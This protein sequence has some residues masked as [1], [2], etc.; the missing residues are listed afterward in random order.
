M[1]KVERGEQAPLLFTQQARGRI[2]AGLGWD[3]R[4][5]KVGMFG[6]ILKTDS[7][8]DLDITAYI[9]NKDGEFIDF[10]GAEAQDSM[11]DSGKIYH[12]GDDMSG[13]GDGDD[14]FI[15]AELMELPGNVHA[16]VFLVEIRSNHVFADIESPF[17]RL[18]DG[19]TNNDLLEIRI[20]H[21][22]A[23]NKNAFVMCSVFKSMAS[24]TG[25]MVYNISEYPDVTNIE[26]WGTY[27]AQFAG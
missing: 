23:A 3:A 6:R 10:V 11:D 25:W 2:I 8:H 5:D 21:D 27:L 20:N 18:A 19:M 24:E 17:T 16:I 4:E 9:Y 12:S 14:E 7:Q 22:E 15:S 26:D 13:E 1:N